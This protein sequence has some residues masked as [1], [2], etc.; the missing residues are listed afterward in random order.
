M[1]YL[2]LSLLGPLQ[3]MRDGQPIAGLTYDKVR[4]LLAYLA[5]EADRPHPREA[6]AGLLWPDQ[7]EEHARHNLRQAL[8]TLR[9][10]LGDQAAPPLLL[11][12]RALV[13]F[14][15]A[16]DYAL[17]VATFSMLL[18]SYQ[19]HPH[20]HVVSCPDCA[21]RL[22]RAIDLY[23]GDFLERFSLRDSAPFEEWVLLMRERLHQQALQAL[24]YLVDYHQQRGAY[25]EAQ[26]YAQRQVELE[27]WRE[28]AHR[29]LMAVLALS[30]R[31]SAA[32]AQYERCRRVLADELGVEPEPETTALYA[33]IRN[34]QIAEPDDQDT[35]RPVHQQPNLWSAPLPHSL[36]RHHNLPPQP[37]PLI[38]RERE[39][40]ELTDLLNNRAC[41][42][43]TLVGPGGCGKTRLALE[44]AAQTATAYMHGVAFVPLAGVSAPSFIVPAIA[45]ALALRFYGPEDPQQ[46]L[47]ANLREKKLLLVLDNFEHLLERVDLLV[48]IL[49]SAPAVKLLVTSRAALHLRWEWLY[50]VEGLAYPPQDAAEGL[51]EYSA[52]QLFV[53]QAR[54][55]QPHFCLSEGDRPAVARICQLVVGMPL[56]IEL[57]A[58]WIRV[59]TCTAIAEHI[60]GNLD[61]LTTLT[62]DIPERHRSVRAVFDHSWN[63][64]TMEAR[65]VFARLSV[66]HGGFRREAAEYIAGADLS[67]LLAL[68]DKSLLFAT[69]AGRYEIHEL[70]RQYAAEKLCESS[71]GIDPIRD[72]HSSYYGE[73]LH[74]RAHYLKGGKQKETLKE[75]GAE[76]ENIRAGWLWAVERGPISIIDMY[77]EGLWC[78]CELRGRFHEAEEIFRSAA[79]RLAYEHVTIETG[80]QAHRRVLGRILVRQ[81]S[82]GMQTGHLD[83]SR[84][85]MQQG[86]LLLQQLGAREELILPLVYLGWLATGLGEYTEAKRLL[87]EAYDVCDEFNDRWGI[88]SSLC[89]VGIVA[90]GLE[91]YAEAQQIVQRSLSVYRSN[92]DTRGITSAL[93]YLGAITLK[94]GEYAKAEQFLQE[95]LRIA[96]EADDLFAIT[97]CL[98]F[99]GHAACAVRADREAWRYFDDALRGLTETRAFTWLLDVL[100]GI[101]TLL[102]H[103]AKHEQALE[104]LALVL[105]HPATLKQTK[106]QAERIRAEIETRLPQY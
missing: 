25:A 90:F 7:P 8:T 47:L 62:S 89:L 93:A 82:F 60:T 30:G 74:Q 9:H 16:N 51:E 73:F 66:F 36:S 50:V 79:E 24:A 33:Q 1:A 71:E 83:Q 31:R 46:Q 97:M 20:S 27:P 101:A 100:V 32:L 88:A 4:A 40:A 96:I 10:A 21:E 70:L 95:A 5:V 6:L 65:M 18:A 68:A 35:R 77:L 14:N 22:T 2:S 29:Q 75:I 48:D 91:E 61:F 26:R 13:Q 37:T 57:A 52:V 72:R 53:Q 43:I 3:I 49:Q 34:G 44:A 103:E 28:E 94:L 104:I 11:I 42:L 81:G 56:A 45:D 67:I 17:D 78:F 92:N 105:N 80:V 15:S 59:L 64:L 84:A 106:D 86:L 55:V 54:R 12:S 85:L 63:L 38:G 41:R 19:T 102:A 58:A 39:L 76:I 87:Q 98:N 99:L 23:R 69:P